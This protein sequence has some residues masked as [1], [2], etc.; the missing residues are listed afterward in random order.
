MQPY[1]HVRFE[2]M[3]RDEINSTIVT[4][5]DVTCANGRSFTCEEMQVSC[6]PADIKARCGLQGARS[7]VAQFAFTSFSVQ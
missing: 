1:I 5:L 2:R 6:S 3:A 7:I 4:T